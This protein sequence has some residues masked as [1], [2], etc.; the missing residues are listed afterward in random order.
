M[1]N[2]Y[3]TFYVTWIN[4]LLMKHKLINFDWIFTNVIVRYL[5]II[6]MNLIKESIQKQLLT[7][8]ILFEI[9]VFKNFAIF[10]GKYLCWSVLNRDFVVNVVKFFKNSFLHIM[11]LVAS[12][13][14]FHKFPRKK[15]RRR[16]R[17]L[18][19][20]KTTK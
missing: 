3:W 11:P 6:H 14:K 13:S 4:L 2:L 5:L 15:S 16:S 12:F 7:E 8:Q 17:F 10:R 19:L 9:V 18:F 20:L 1:S